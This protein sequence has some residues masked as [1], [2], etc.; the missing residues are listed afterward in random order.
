MSQEACCCGQAVCSPGVSPHQD[1]SGTTPRARTLHCSTHLFGPEHLCARLLLHKH[2]Q[3][4]AWGSWETVVWDRK[5]VAHEVREREK[6]SEI[7]R[8]K[9]VETKL[10]EELALKT[11][12]AKGHAAEKA[13]LQ[14]AG[15]RLSERLKGK[16]EK[17]AQRFQL[18]LERRAAVA[19][20]L[21][22]WDRWYVELASSRALEHAVFRRRRAC[23]MAVVRAWERRLKMV[24]RLRMVETTLRRRRAQQSSACVWASWLAWTRCK[25]RRRILYTVAG[26]TIERKRNEALVYGMDSWRQQMHERRRRVRAA[27]WRLWAVL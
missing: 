25:R 26:K 10:H 1:P 27:V 16:N 4:F 14:T 7:A 24:Q 17:K 12:R 22:A 19:L 5:T 11:L 2:P 6:D 8:L 18:R 21:E 13:A 23:S 3:H 9:A 15:E 20:L